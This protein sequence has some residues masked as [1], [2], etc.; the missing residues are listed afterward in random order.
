MADE[1]K[2]SKT[3][4]P[5]QKKLDEARQKGNLANSKELGN[6]FMLL[7]LAITVAWFIPSILKNS[8][9]LLLR[10]QQRVIL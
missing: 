2:D 6:F 10:E 4:E 7:V 3:E 9:S 8:E 5:S 1:D